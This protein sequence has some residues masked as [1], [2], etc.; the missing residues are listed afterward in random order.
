MVRVRP[1]ASLSL[2]LDNEWSYL[3]TRGDD[4]WATYPSYLDVVVP[5]VLDELDRLGLR[6]TFFIVGQDAA[7]REH[8]DVLAEIPR[9]GHEVGNHSFRH[10]PWLH[11]Y[12]ADEV[13]DEI[14]R[15]GD[16]VER[17]TGQRPRGFRGPGYSLS[18]PTLRALVR[19]G[20]EY[21]ASTLPTY[22]GPLARAYYFRRAHLDEAERREREVLFGTL[23]DG[24]RPITP[25]RWRVDDTTL[26]EI[27]V[28]TF[29][30]VKVPFHV[31]YL[32]TLAGVSPAAAR[33]YLRTAL[34]ACRAAGVG[35]SILLHPLDF[36][37]GKDAPGLD[38]FP[39][40]AT[41]WRDKLDRVATYLDA[42]RRRLD[43]RPVGEHAAA[44]GGRRLK[45]REPNFAAAAAA[46]GHEVAA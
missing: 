41:P 38:F 32:L 31:S 18:L 37:D 20:Y 42:F 16:A 4:T 10:E 17:A 7:Q 14:A 29:P 44:L 15:T 39:G 6:I 11:R 46:A 45:I 12:S 26:L 5:R 36:L 1:V 19:Q 8:H 3:K 43:V 25:Y 27:P 23:R 34:A 21:D 9:R 30:G 13:D 24:L 40:M 22:L 2:D 35:P 33:A 28:T